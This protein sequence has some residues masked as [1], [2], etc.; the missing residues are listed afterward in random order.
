MQYS[1]IWDNK[2]LALVARTVE[3]SVWIR[4]L[5]VQ[6]PNLLRHFLSQK[7]RHFLK[8]I[9][10]WVVNECC[11]LCT[12]DISNVNFKNTHIYI[13]ICIWTKSPVTIPNLSTNA[14]SQR[15]NERVD[16]LTWSKWLIHG[17]KHHK[18]TQLQSLIYPCRSSSDVLLSGQVSNDFIH[19]IR[20]YPTGAKLPHEF[21]FV[22]I[23]FD[24]C[25][26]KH[27]YFLLCTAVIW[28]TL[29]YCGREKQAGI[30]QTISNSFSCMK[31]ILFWFKF[32]WIWII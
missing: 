4:R 32:L 12:I 13:Y 23:S 18:A 16:H 6:E 19:T 7:L 5:G 25:E 8:Y 11:C 14:R 1:K 29:T 3:H 17:T 27:K 20:G 21:N 15:V 2:C 28:S 30:G 22:T 10:S 26:L 31:L 24:F 9:R